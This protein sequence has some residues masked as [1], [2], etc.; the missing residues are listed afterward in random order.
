MAKHN[1]EPTAD[2]TTLKQ[3]AQLLYDVR[4]FFAQR[5]VLEVETPILSQAAPTA[6]YLDSFKTDFIPLGTEQKQSYYLHTSPE[7]AMK[8]LLAAGVGSIYQMTKVFRNGE[9]GWLHS[10][11]FTMLEWYRP[12]LDLDQLMNEVADLLQQV[13]GISSNTRLAYQAVFNSLLNIDVLCCS[14]HELEQLAKQKLSSLSADF[15]LDRDGWLELLMSEVIEPEL[16][17]IDQAVF[18][19]DFPA[20]QA[21]LAKVKTD[22]Q[23]RQVAARFELYAGGLELANGYDELLDAPELRQRFEQDNQQRQSLG[24]PE[25]PMDE[26][27]LAAME[28][29]LPQCTGVALGLERLLMLV[30]G[31]RS[32][33]ETQ[34]IAVD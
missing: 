31:M 22:E 18:I 32:I 13:F 3:R 17:K 33:G 5:Q 11:E 12:E 34:S 16:A 6:P 25:M 10:P 15:K 29:G 1:W 23:G 14:D 28:A 30:L 26:N 19:Y 24:K 4:H 8:R 2:L 20:S 7:F 9:Q 21:Q 27:L